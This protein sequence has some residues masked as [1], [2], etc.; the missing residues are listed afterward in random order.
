MIEFSVLD[1]AAWA[2]GLATRSEWQQWATAPWLPQ[3][4]GTPGLSDVPAM[5]RRRIERLGRMAIQ[6]A[7]WCEDG[8]GADSTVPLVFAS[9]HGDV[10]RSMELLRALV[11]EEA[12]SPTTF[13]L[14]VHNAIGALYSITRGHRGNLLAL[15]AGKAT[16]EAACL[17]AAGLLADGARE[18]RVVVYDPPLPAL[19]SAFS[20]EPSTYYAWCW[21]LA[22]AVPGRDRLRL[23]WR[24]DAA[25]DDAPGLLPHAL[26]LQRFLLAGD[27][28]CTR[29]VDGQRWSWHR[30]D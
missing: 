10:E 13:G 12:L 27:D 23:Q 30:G 1:W 7:C 19:Y 20:D 11:A 9:R 28:R 8:Q 2:P 25:P 22:A 4:D 14:S 18:V 15:S 6:A 17:E 29:V 16:V 5:Q 24:A 3:G 21:R 26:E